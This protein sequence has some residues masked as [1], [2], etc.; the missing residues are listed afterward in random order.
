MQ[1]STSIS[2]G[3]AP[4]GAHSPAITSE[5]EAALE[6]CFK[7]TSEYQ[8]LTR[9]AENE[10]ARSL[11]RLKQ[12]RLA[13]SKDAISVMRNIQTQIQNIQT[14][15]QRLSDSFMPGRQEEARDR[16]SC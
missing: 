13:Q 8:K 6:K 16:I 4:P 5:E 1:R 14:Q 7:V 15:I 3:G 10:K 9:E 2:E 12:K 11:K